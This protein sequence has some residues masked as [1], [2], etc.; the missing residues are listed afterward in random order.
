MNDWKTTV[1]G[2]IA[3]MATAAIPFFPEYAVYLGAIAAMGTAA[4]GYFAK[5][6]GK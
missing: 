2:L 6:T 5:Q 1:P 3:A 4:L